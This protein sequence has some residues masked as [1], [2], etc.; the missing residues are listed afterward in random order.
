MDIKEAVEHTCIEPEFFHA[1]LERDFKALSKFNVK[2][3]LK[4]LKREY[5]IDSEEF[6]SEYN[7]YLNADKIENSTEKKESKVIT[8]VDQYSK[9]GSTWWLWA[10]IVIVATAIVVIVYKFDLFKAFVD[11]S[12]SKNASTQ[13]IENINEAQMAVQES[14]EIEPISNENSVSNLDENS[15]LNSANSAS[16]PS[17][18]LSENSNKISENSNTNE[19]LNQASQ[20]GKV[21][22][23]TSGKVWVGFIDLATK[24]N[25]SVV[26]DEDFEVDLGTDQLILVGGT[27]LTLTDEKGEVQEFPAG[28]S[29]RFLV[30]DGTIR[31]I[32]ISEFRAYNG[33]REW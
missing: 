20:S 15:T 18:N 13:V 6:E 7:A 9:E 8:N 1:L 26:T 11:E 28:N 12:E 33:G 4:I 3:F 5:D 22:F 17:E 24:A 16:N 19:P 32:S 31:A 23:S 2:G 21:V 29:K 25:S 30:K 27:A 10:L 14:G